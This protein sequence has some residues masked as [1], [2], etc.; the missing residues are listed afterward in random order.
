MPENT[1]KQN[2]LKAI[3]MDDYQ[4]WFVTAI[5]NSVDINDVIFLSDL[6][7]LDAYF[8]FER[9]HVYTTNKRD[10]KL[11]KSMIKEFSSR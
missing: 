4:I 6:F 5:P 3:F 11:I 7:K 1:E 2:L 8:D 9:N 10:Y